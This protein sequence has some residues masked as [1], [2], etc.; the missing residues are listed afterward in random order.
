M[1]RID[2]LADLV[3]C[4]DLCGFL[5]P[6]VQALQS[7]GV[8]LGG[9]PAVLRPFRKY[10]L[11]QL[12]GTAISVRNVESLTGHLLALQEF[13]RAE[14][15]RAPAVTQLIEAMVAGDPLRI[16]RWLWAGSGYLQAVQDFASQRLARAHLDKRLGSIDVGFSPGIPSVAVVVDAVQRRVED[17]KSHIER[18]S[19]ASDQCD[20]ADKLRALLQELEA[21]RNSRVQLRNRL[22][23]DVKNHSQ[24]SP[25][26]SS[27][28]REPI[29]LEEQIAHHERVLEHLTFQAEE[30]SRKAIAAR[31]HAAVWAEFARDPTTGSGQLEYLITVIRPQAT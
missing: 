10:L 12:R 13:R 31:V 14:Q 28:M 9:T 8:H 27:T 5:G 6:V 21:S 20:Q 3:S 18:P 26:R 7:Q 29:A 23:A 17:A 1:R 25:K 22:R 30:R 15:W 11:E 4:A 2:E 19:R 16:R 24:T